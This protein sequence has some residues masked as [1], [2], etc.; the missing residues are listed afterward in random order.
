[1]T[2]LR[3]VTFVNFILIFLEMLNHF[4]SQDVVI[5][6]IEE[7]IVDVRQCVVSL[8]FASI[9]EREACVSW[10]FAPIAFGAKNLKQV[11][12]LSATADI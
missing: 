9:V 3:A 8:S 6:T 10:N 1:M 4:S 7:K 12:L 11:S 5:K 2:N